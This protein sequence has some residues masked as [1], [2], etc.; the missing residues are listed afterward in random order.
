MSV[1]EVQFFS[2][3][4][5]E[6]VAGSGLATTVYIGIYTRCGIPVGGDVKKSIASSFFYHNHISFGS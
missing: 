4:D 5:R 1:S 2:S 3:T 6:N